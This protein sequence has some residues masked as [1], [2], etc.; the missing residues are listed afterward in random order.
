M[1]ENS[2][3]CTTGAMEGGLEEPE[4]RKE[5]VNGRGAR[6]LGLCIQFKVLRLYSEA[7]IGAG[8]WLFLFLPC[9][10]HMEVPG[11][12]IRSKLQL[13][14]MPQLQQCWILNPLCRSGNSGRF[15]FL[16]AFSGCSVNE[17][18]ICV[19]ENGHLIWTIKH[20]L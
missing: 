13:Q 3:V 15:L 17:V 14:P 10:R 6:P 5:A 20:F 16:K 2:K 11:R 7:M 18:I 8:F 1:Y 12:G 4:Q 9:P 19:F